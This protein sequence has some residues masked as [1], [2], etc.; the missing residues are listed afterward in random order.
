MRTLGAQ[1]GSTRRVSLRQ[2]LT[3]GVALSV[4]AASAVIVGTSVPALATVSGVTVTPIR[5][6]AGATTNYTVAFTTTVA[7]V[8][9]VDSITLVGPTRHRSSQLRQAP[10][11]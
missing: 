6:A 4:A 11:P 2:R 5:A 10:T 9:D 7:L 3:A 1:D 8:I